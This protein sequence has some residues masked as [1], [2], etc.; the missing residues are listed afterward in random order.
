MID[1]A[2]YTMSSCPLRS[3]LCVTAIGSNAPNTFVRDRSSSTLSTP[4][5]NP[6]NQDP[7]HL[8]QGNET[9]RVSGTDTGPSVLDG[10]AVGC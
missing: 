5:K 4:R 8:L 2:I 7:D 3:L 1:D 6:C 9:G 10:L